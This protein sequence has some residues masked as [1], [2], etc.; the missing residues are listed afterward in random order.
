M[1]LAIALVLSLLLTICS[2]TQSKQHKDSS[3]LVVTYYGKEVHRRSSVY[4]SMSQLTEF[5]HSNKRKYIIFGAPSCPPCKTLIRALEQSGHKD[6]VVFLNLEEEW[7]VRL[8]SMANLRS[9]PSMIVADRFGTPEK[10]LNGA[11]EIV[12]YLLINVPT[13]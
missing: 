1:R 4:S 13:E 7:V 10:I 3:E 8:H 6:M 12:M 9:I 2:G 5:L 11:S